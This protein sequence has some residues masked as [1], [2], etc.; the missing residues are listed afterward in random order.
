LVDVV[1]F[2]V[3]DFAGVLLVVLDELDTVRLALLEA[4][5]DLIGEVLRLEGDG[6]AFVD[7]SRVVD[8]FGAASAIAS[9][10]GVV[11]FGIAAR[12]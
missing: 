7:V 9:I 2:L 10:R 5:V 11:F 6:A 1:D 3:V 8:A 4:F 12:T